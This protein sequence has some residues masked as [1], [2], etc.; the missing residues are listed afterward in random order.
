LLRSEV[1]A[2]VGEFI[3]FHFTIRLICCIISL[4]NLNI[5]VCYF[6]KVRV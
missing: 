3:S 1:P 2:G 5:H 6:D 4:I